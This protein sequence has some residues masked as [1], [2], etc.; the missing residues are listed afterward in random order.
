MNA[1]TK[2]LAPAAL[3]L[4]A[5][6]AQAATISTGGETYGSQAIPEAASHSSV[7]AMP[8]S[9]NT[10]GETYMGIT[11]AS[12]SVAGPTQNAESSDRG[13]ERLYLG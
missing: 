8:T 4:F 1:I 5:F 2:V 13:L 12:N 6:G 7:V 3:A 10:G 9:V 11:N